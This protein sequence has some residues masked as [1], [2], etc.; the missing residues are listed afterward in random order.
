[1]A[2]TDGSRFRPA[3]R[4]LAVTAG[5]DHDH[6]GVFL[7]DVGE[8]V[9]RAS[10]NRR[11]DREADVDAFGADFRD[12]PTNLRLD[13]SLSTFSDCPPARPTSISRT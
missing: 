1:M 10:G 7:R 3:P 8:N 11:H 2:A 13:P 12:L 4:D 5:A 9:R 6:I